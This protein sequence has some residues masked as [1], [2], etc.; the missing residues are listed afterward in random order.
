[1]NA[2][3]SLLSLA[4]VSGLALSATAVAGNRVNDGAITRANALIAGSASSAIHRVSGDA[5]SVRDVIT[6]ANG[7]E[8]VR[9]NR[10][11]RGLPVIGGGFVV[12]S[13]N[14]RQIGKV[15]QTLRSAARPS[16]D[17]RISRDEAIVEA[18]ARFGTRFT[19]VP[20]AR[21]VIW[22]RGAT[23]VLAQEVVFTGIKADQSPTEMHY[24]VDAA[25][26]RILA[27]Y[28]GVQTARRRRPGPNGGGGTCTSP[29]PATG[30]GNALYLGSVTLATSSCT[31]GGYAMIDS[32]R[33]NSGGYNRTTDMGN[34]TSGSG[35]LFTD[36]DNVWG[37]G[38]NSNRQSAGVDAHYGITMTWDYYLNKHGRSGIDGAGT[39]AL[40]R[41]HYG[42]NYGNANWSD[43][44][45]CMTFGDGDGSVLGP[46]VSLDVAGHEMSHGVT[47]HTAGLIYDGESGGLNEG[48]SDIFGT[49][50]EFYAN[51]A[52]DPGDYL[53]G[54]KVFLNGDILRYMFKPSLDGISPDCWYDGIGGL[55]VHY[56][57]G[58]ANHFFYLLAA[59]AVV[60]SGYGA[61]SPANLDPSDLVCNGNTAI[62]GIGNDKAG[63]IWYRA[64]SVYMT[65]STDYHGARDATLDA[66]TDL[67]G[68]GSTE[69]NAVAAAWDAV[70]VTAAVAAPPSAPPQ[71][72][73]R[74]R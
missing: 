63:A 37:N 56:N 32:T 3:K 67:Y 25:N 4:I 47:S 57:S 17:A 60:P 18:G 21:T 1:M 48:T 9:Y 51:N 8:H 49:L 10:T 52:S 26:G 6:D 74:R 41:V 14:G 2:K 34:L 73:N 29:S 43:S 36:A 53:I 70:D 59:G 38:L 44:C 46:L 42:N 16:L 54:E 11:Y 12:H 62:V 40:S 15:S 35:T 39:G 13:R 33:G 71:R 45:Y 69:A 50:V 30:T 20:T 31:N 7:T 64:L 68:A 61:G 66:A 58:I 65:D 5:F 72:R 19:G 27:Q 23:P 28:D 24:I 55:D 22:A